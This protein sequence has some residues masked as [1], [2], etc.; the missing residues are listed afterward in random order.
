M[1]QSALQ[2]LLVAT[3]IDELYDLDHRHQSATGVAM[4]IHCPH[5]QN[6]IEVVD[7]AKPHDVVC[8]SCG[9]SFNWSDLPTSPA[10]AQAPPI[11]RLGRL[12]L[13]E[14]L[15]QGAFGSVWRARDPEL[16]VERAVKLAGRMSWGAARPRSGFCARR[17]RRRT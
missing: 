16:G 6:A 11:A 14:Q 7:S 8:L 5:C 4:H 1:W 9:S 2:E 13:M 15:G 12:V 3:Q 17:V 10:E